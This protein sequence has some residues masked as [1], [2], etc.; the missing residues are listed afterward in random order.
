MLK[1]HLLVGDES[2]YPFCMAEEELSQSKFRLWHLLVSVLTLYWYFY[3]L[4]PSTN[5]ILGRQ[6]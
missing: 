2:A 5:S 4:I 1:L 3:A 6:E